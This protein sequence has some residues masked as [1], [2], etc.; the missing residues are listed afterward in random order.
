MKALL[1][2]LAL[3]LSPSLVFAQMPNGS[4][5]TGGSSNNG[6][7]K[8]EKTNPNAIASVVVVRWFSPDVKPADVEKALKG[9]DFV[10]G[11]NMRAEEQIVAVNYFGEFR[12]IDR[13]R[14]LVA[15]G[16]A[17]T[18]SPC[19]MRL[20]FRTLK[21]AKDPSTAKLIEAVRK[22]RGI[23]KE[24][25][26]TGGGASLW[27]DAQTFNL[28]TVGAVAGPL[29]FEVTSETHEA[30]TIRWEYTAEHQSAEP[31]FKAVMV[32]KGVM[33][34]LDFNSMDKRLV[35]QCEK[36]SLG[37]AAIKAAIQ[38]AGFKVPDAKK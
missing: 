2:L 35:V 28:R 8:E 9:K 10:Q 18:L 3:F 26:L 25:S 29:G 13:V 5:K 21:D 14:Q 1:A 6:G 22:V 12:S 19:K 31:L 17:V 34:S 20:S 24:E 15:G 38:K 33:L 4:D 30:V 16:N 27:V 11:V 7:K 32:L 23:E 37:D 36:G